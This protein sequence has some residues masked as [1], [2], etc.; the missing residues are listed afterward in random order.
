L[1]SS[2]CKLELGVFLVGAIDGDL[3][4]VAQAWRV[5]RHMIG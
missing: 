3:R 1:F 2:G 5:A 4:P